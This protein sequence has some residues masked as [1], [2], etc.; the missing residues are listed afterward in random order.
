MNPGVVLGPCLTKAHT[1]ASPVVVRQVLYGNE[2]ANYRTSFVDVRDVAAAHVEALGR[3]EAGG[4]RFI[5][6]QGETMLVCSVGEHAQRLFPDLRVEGK[7]PAPA[8]VWCAW[9]LSFLPVIGSK[10]MTAYQ[11]QMLKQTFQYDNTRSRQELGLSYHS[12]DDTVRDTVHSMIDARD[13]GAGWVKPKR[14]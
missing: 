3:P 8:K 10:F 4:K 11:S 2:Q 14:K 5:C 1:K 7:E 9:A 12:L 13:G 6:A